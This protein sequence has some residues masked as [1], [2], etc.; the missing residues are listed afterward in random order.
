[1]VTSDAPQLSTWAS[2]NRCFSVNP[3]RAITT[4]KICKRQQSRRNYK[5]RVDEV[6]LALTLFCFVSTASSA[7]PSVVRVLACGSGRASLQPSPGDVSSSVGVPDALSSDD[8]I[9]SFGT[10]FLTEFHASTNVPVCRRHAMMHD[11]EMI[12]R[13]QRFDFLVLQE[14]CEKLSGDLALE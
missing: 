9:S 4:S 6:I 1:M 10:K 3:S 5:M 12:F 2:Q 13:Q 7:S 8:A 14:R 11:R